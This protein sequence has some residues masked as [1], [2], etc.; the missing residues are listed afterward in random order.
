MCGD[1]N[2]H[3]SPPPRG[4]VDKH[5]PGHSPLRTEKLGSL[6]TYG[7]SSRNAECE[8]AKAEQYKLHSDGEAKCTVPEAESNPY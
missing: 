3:F 7:I 8:V 1:S 5:R 2:L 6:T 4:D